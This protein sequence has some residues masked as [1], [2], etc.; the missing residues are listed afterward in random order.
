M[1][2]K[3]SKQKNGSKKTGSSQANEVWEIIK[4]ISLIVGILAGILSIIH[5]L[6]PRDYS[7]DIMN[8]IAEIKKQSFVME[9]MPDSLLEIPTVKQARDVQKK[10]LTIKDC[11]DNIDFAPHDNED[12]QMGIYRYVKE[13]ER[14][15]TLCNEV[16][17]CNELF[18]VFVKN[19]PQY[20]TM[21]N[22]SEYNKSTNKQNELSEKLRTSIATSLGMDKS[23]EKKLKLLK[24]ALNSKE[25]LE[26]IDIQREVLQQVFDYMNKVQREV[27]L[28]HNN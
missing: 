6:I 20:G 21:F 11:I 26:F 24:K 9:Q 13:M 12:T 22:L 18:S 28:N 25:M 19:N 17:K 27:K 7:K 3:V 1:F 10:I 14:F 15:E 2:K 23:P 5:F 4:K 16:I 8:E